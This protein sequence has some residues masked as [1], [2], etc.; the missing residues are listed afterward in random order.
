MKG[1]LTATAIAAA[2]TAVLLA[3]PAAANDDPFIAALNNAGVQVYGN[4]ILAGNVARQICSGLEYG[5]MPSIART[6]AQDEYGHLT[7][8]QAATFVNLSIR[9]YCPGIGQ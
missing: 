7:E 5:W 1:H 8:S 9:H 2:A 4:P 3:P 6:V